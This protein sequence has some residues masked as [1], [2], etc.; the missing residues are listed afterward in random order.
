M[1][2]AQSTLGF[3]AGLAEGLAG[4]FSAKRQNDQALARDRENR[5]AQIGMGVLNHLI[6][7]GRIASYDDLMPYVDLTLGT[8]GK[9]PKKGEISPHDILSQV[10]APTFSAAGGAGAAASGGIPSASPP[11][12]GVQATPSD[13][14]VVADMGRTATPA[15][16]PAA[17]AP[18]A[19]PASAPTA[20]TGQPRQSGIRLLSDAEMVERQVSNEGI[21]EKATMERRSKLAREL[22]EQ[23]KTVDNDFTLY[24]ALAMAGFRT[25]YNRQY[26][27]TASGI[28]RGFDA[29]VQRKAQ[30]LGR[31][32]TTAE[33][34]E[35]RTTWFA[36]N[37][38]GGTNRE[39]L[40][41][42]KFGQA[43]NLLTPPQQQEIIAAETALIGGQSYAR[44]A[45]GNQADFNA[46]L[47]PT[48]AQ[49]AN[50]PVGTT[51]PQVAG[52]SI[53][54]DAEV[55]Q[56]RSTE[57]LKTTLADIRDRLVPAA[58][59]KADSLGG[60]APGAAF[61]LRRRSPE[62]RDQIAALESAVNNVVNVAA[63]TVAGQ[64]G[65]Q[66]EKDA[67]RAE[68]AIVALKDAVLTGDTVESATVRINESLKIIDEVLSKLPQQ[69]VP[70]TGTAQGGRSTGN[71]TT[72]GRFSTKYNN[73]TYTFNTQ[74]KLDAFKRRYGIR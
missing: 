1:P 40:A 6:T 30:E 28:M 9:K 66:T 42:A 61:A 37:R 46:P 14:A 69:A 47:T 16:A 22:Y 55:E 2:D 12:A 65:A 64:R 41:R 52:Q 50:L 15:G 43:F 5:N 34:E 3:G 19:A 72:T 27:S 32:L 53:L 68:A 48:Q 38:S 35:L 57:S 8:G 49:T 67:A 60:L 13:A 7:S 59:P 20:P 29:Q 17:A 4:V 70:T 24:D 45:A 71:A 36:A 26:G 73:K 62:F 10:L 25:D 33:T 23:F 21:A 54:K 31:P 74:A 11:A 51:G 63:R 44:T 18:V 56:R 58:L 39:A